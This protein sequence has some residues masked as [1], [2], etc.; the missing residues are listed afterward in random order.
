PTPVTRIARQGGGQDRW[1]FFLPD[2]KHFIYFV[3]WSAPGIYVGSLDSGEPKLISSE[4]SG[5]VAYGAGNLLYVRDRRLMAQPFSV[6][7]LETTGPPVAIAQQELEKDPAFSQ[8]GFSASGNGVLVF[9]SAADSPSRLIWF[10]SSGKE[11]QQMP[12]VGYNYPHL[13]PSGRFLVI[14]SDDEHNGRYYARV[15]DLERGVSTRLSDTMM[16]APG[17]IWSRD[18]KRITYAAVRGGIY[19]V[20]EI[21]SDGSGAPRVLLKGAKMIPNDWSP[22][23]HLVLMDWAKGLPQHLVVYSAS[24]HQFMELAVEGAEA[25]FSPDGKWIAYV[26]PFDVVV[27]PFPGPG[28]RIQI[29]SA[30][31]GQPRWSR[32]GRQIF[33]IQPD[34]KLMAVSFDPKK[35]SAGAPR[36]LFQT[37]IVAPNFALFQYDVSPD[38]RFLINSFPS[39]SSSPLTVLTGWTALLKGR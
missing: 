25:Q 38:G 9:Q 27:Q 39:N 37:R 19:Y 34:R 30:R 26:T 1:P 4:L 22:D 5:T 16:D 10:D 8:A 35:G 17:M 36:V 24:D 31:G 11:L 29:S 3:N 6:D 18:G 28:G 15:Y 23:G 14:F 21:A 13:S 20:E 12:E 7:R 2:G 33:Y 32:D